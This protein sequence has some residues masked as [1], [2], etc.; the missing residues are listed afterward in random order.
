MSESAAAYR[1]RVK[2][3]EPTAREYQARHPGRHHAEMRMVHQAFEFV[4]RWHRVLDVPCGGGRVTTQLAKNGYTVTAADLSD[5]MIQIAR[6]T[7]AKE[8]LRCAVTKED[9]EK[10]T[11]GDRGFDTIVCFRLFHHFPT[12]GV[13]QRAATEL[14]RVA[15]KYVVLSYFSPASVTSVKR[16][17]R[18]ALGGRKSEKHSTPLSEVQGYFANAGFRL[19]RD[20]AQL[21]IIHTM[22]LA[23][24]ERVGENRP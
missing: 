23:L 9:V 6:E 12:P 8:Q 16:K 4:P 3:D 11:F 2:Y 15:R 19:V 21:P 14:C 10:L 13:R 20:F 18:V 1:G 5:A 17:L 7:V 22:H 24:F